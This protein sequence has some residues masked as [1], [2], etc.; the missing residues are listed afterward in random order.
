MVVKCN[1]F[2]SLIGCGDM[3]S[4]PLFFSIESL[5][6]SCRI[7]GE[8][9][10]C[11]EGRAAGH[12]GCRLIIWDGDQRL[13]NGAHYNWDASTAKKN[14]I[15]QID[16]EIQRRPDFNWRK[17]DLVFFPVCANFHYYLVVYWMKKNTIEI[18]DNNK[19]H[20]NMDPFEKYDIDIGLMSGPQARRK[21]D[22]G[23]YLM[24]H[25]E[26][27]VGKKGSEWDIGFSA[28]SVKIPH[29]LRGRYCYTMI[30]SIYNN[31]RSP[32]LQLAHDWIEANMD[33][34]L[35]LNNKYT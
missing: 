1:D 5:Q 13:D 2:V 23:V 30:S 6:E 25:M 32:M 17:I 12:H 28:R 22:C 31:Q 27:Y 35:E 10:G 24:R 33:K 14:F 19:P 21:K 16:N 26:T 8:A 29:I 7:T 3:L 18:I 15:S 11:H 34:L 4:Y 9:N 20:K